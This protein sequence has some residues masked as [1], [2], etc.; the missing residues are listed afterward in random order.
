MYRHRPAA[1][2]TEAGNK[3][4]AG[5]LVPGSF[6]PDGMS[7]PVIKTEARELLFLLVAA[8]RRNLIGRWQMVFN[9]FWGL[10]QDFVQGNVIAHFSGHFFGIGIYRKGFLS[11]SPTGRT[12]FACFCGILPG[13]HLAQEL[14]Y[15]PPD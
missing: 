6:F 9:R 7:C 5:L 15:I 11:G 13:L 3:H 12:Y 2:A 14:V 4:F 8:I 10:T 1:R